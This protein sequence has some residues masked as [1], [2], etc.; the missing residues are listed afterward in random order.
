MGARANRT[1]RGMLATAGALVWLAAGVALADPTANSLGGQAPGGAPGAAPGAAPGDA[2]ANALAP[3][4]APRAGGPNEPVVGPQD[5]D[6]WTR[7]ADGTIHHQQSGLACPAKIGDVSLRVGTVFPSPLGRG[8]DVGCDYGRGG[9]G[10]V[11]RAADAKLTIFAVKL[12]PG[13]TLE[14]AFDRYRWEMH[15]TFPDT[16]HSGPLAVPAQA[17]G[18]APLPELRSE[19]D[20]ITIDGKPYRTEVVVA[21]IS[22][23]VVEIRST[24]PADN[25]SDAQGAMAALAQAASSMARSI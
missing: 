22:N 23:W 19:G 18:A 8:M 3:D 21:I 6:V 2:T 17:E 13:V 12:S 16:S 5:A 14:S 10:A 20:D 24:Y 1:T 7:D 4:A 9:Y 15:H 25:T 11:G